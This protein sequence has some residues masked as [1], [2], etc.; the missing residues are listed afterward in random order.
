M[1]AQLLFDSAK[2]DTNVRRATVVLMHYAAQDHRVII[3]KSTEI[4]F[5]YGT[6]RV[7][8]WTYWITQ[9]KSMFSRDC[10]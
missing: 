4:N 7:C 8:Q 3:F 5:D 2:K 10:L 1:M 9:S 6:F